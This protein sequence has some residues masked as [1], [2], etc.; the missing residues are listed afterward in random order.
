MSLL[1]PADTGL[2]DH[3]RAAADEVGTRASDRLATAHDASHYLL[4]PQAV[5][6]PRNRE[7]VTALFSASRQSRVPMTFRSGGTS[8]SGQ[9]VSGGVL[10]DTRRHFRDIDVLD[11]GARV[12][13]GPGAVVRAVNARLL[14]HG[15]KLGP[16]PASEIACTIGGV[17][18]NNSSGMA[19][20]IEANTYQTLD[21][22]VL[23]LPSGTVLDTSAADADEQLRRREPAI[24]A[25][26]AELRDRIRT[27]VEAVARITQLH[28]IKNTMGY[29]LNSFLDHDDPVRILEHLVIGSEGTLA[30]VAEATFRTVPLMA[31]A[32]TGLLVFADLP[33]AT[34]VL[35]EIIAT[36]AAT[37]ELLDATSLRV[38]QRDE[39]CPEEI[40]D[41][42]VDSH[43]ALLVEFQEETEEGLGRVVSAALPVFDTFSLSRPAELTIDPRRRSALWHTRKGLFT[44]V[45]GN[46]PSGT[47]AL[48]E[49]IAVPVDRLGETCTALSE[50]FEH[51]DYADAVIFGHAK[52]GN[53]HFMI[54]EEFGSGTDGEDFD[55]DR[56]AAFTEEMVDLVLSRGGTLKAEHGTGRIMA[57]FVRRQVGDD[58]YAVMTRVKELVDPQSL[59][60]PG[61]LL[62]DDPKA[63]LRDLKTTPTTEE[64]VDRCV[65]CGYCEP[66][67]PSRDLTLTPRERIVLRREI[68]RAEA[69]GDEEL[70][71]TLR[72]EYDYD[73][74]DTCAVDGMCQ[75]ACPVF[76]N[77]GDLVRRLRQENTNAIEETGWNTAAK[78]WGLVSSVG[79][80]AL[81]SAKAMPTR[82][83]AAATG[84]GRRLLGDDTVPSYSADLPA[85]G[86]KRV[87]VSASNPDVVWFSSCTNTM[88][89]PEDGG[90]GDGVAGAF[91]RL[92][93]RAGIS[94]RTPRGIPSL[95]CGT[96]WKSK[97]MAEGFATMRK[98]VRRELWK[99]TD[100]GRIA[101]V[102][103]ASS[104]TEGLRVLL[105]DTKDG[106]DAGDGADAA[107]EFEIIDAV[108][109]AKQTLLPAL[110]DRGVLSTEHRLPSITLHPT[111][112]STQLGINEDLSA[113]AGSVADEVSVPDS[114]GCCAFAGDR[115]M[116]H[117]ELTA[118]ATKDE[119]AEVESISA[120]VHASTNR[121]CEIGMTR[122]TGK[123]YRHILEA[124]DD[125][126][127]Q[128]SI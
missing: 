9:S 36:G 81:S 38:A 82:L 42:N 128:S 66:V 52:D 86:S 11:D 7:E 32:S 56:Y 34:S 124:L 83:P 94:L 20:G 26:L 30:F 44:A 126:V 63:H 104:C 92:C 101:V 114:W 109:F 120:D 87:A 57:P 123:P 8:L 18:A 110:Q 41:L 54:T 122:A 37:V 100:G 24:H 103:D 97:G 13:C 84:I 70:T 45:A 2:I 31:H 112:S 99:A 79:G 115:G 12:R 53:I 29:G 106:A 25:G 108:A 88:F 105:G 111:C 49:D 3:L 98:Y 5:V 74:I 22:L 16:D 47:A 46:R 73:G 85:G 102:C 75:T 117:P 19:C 55:L 93:E 61:V 58:L 127:G 67:C 113:L 1:S 107:E 116:L 23:V 27:D 118:S 6:K 77:T 4:T 69:A 35:P 95:C 96:P 59:L 50:L 15:R 62:S 28:S 33:T 90:S 51:Y 65:E 60:N 89:G 21:S 91:R 10:V 125:L 17:V 68:A 78:T 72:S 39:K 121:T 76:I 48:L 40:R 43:C 14:R 119:A 80:A 64:E 71:R